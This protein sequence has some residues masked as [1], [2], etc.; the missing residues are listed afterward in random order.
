MA[1]Y[2]ITGSRNCST[3]HRWGETN[4]RR[5][6]RRARA[7]TQSYSTLD[8]VY[9]EEAGGRLLYHLRRVEGDT[10]RVVAR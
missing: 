9:V 4:K 5:A 2:T 7:L 10:W 6:Y 8:D 3:V 1:T